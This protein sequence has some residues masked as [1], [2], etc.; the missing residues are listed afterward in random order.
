MADDRNLSV[1][2]YR[3]YTEKDAQLAAAE[4]K[5]I[6]YLEARIDYSRPDSILLVYEKTIHERIFRTPVGLQ[7]LKDLRDFLLEQPEM[8]PQRVPEIPLYN[9]FSGEVRE[10]SAPARNRIRADS[11]EK[12]GKNA[13]FTISVILNV[14]L[15]LAVICMFTITLRSDHPNVLNYERVLTDRYA[16]WEQDLT[17]R[18]NV[19]REKE[20]ELKLNGDAEIFTE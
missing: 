10:K 5:K 17:E 12:G 16:Q 1:G 18:E 2:G 14:L 7:Y 13:G 6:E 3:F 11:G 15:V 20:R 8:D 19:I 4:L 9:T